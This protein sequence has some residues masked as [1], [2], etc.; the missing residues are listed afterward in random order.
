M[1]VREREHDH[2]VALAPTITA[3]L[4]LWKGRTRGA[5]FVFPSPTGRDHI[6]RESLEKA[7]RVTLGLAK[8][9]S[10]HGWRAAL[11]TLARDAGF[12]REVVELALDHIH[13]TAVARA[14][15]RGERLG[16]RRRLMAWWDS[17]LQAVSDDPTVLP[18]R[19]G[20]A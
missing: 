11:S 5:G 6:T 16:E 8:K 1:K 13:D 9:H 2:K 19:T 17:Q 18:I 15:D 20:A 10:L 12:S 3:E 7:Y 14:Y 4:R